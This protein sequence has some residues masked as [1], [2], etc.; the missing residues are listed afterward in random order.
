MMQKTIQ[1]WDL[2]FVVNLHQKHIKG[3]NSGQVE[4]PHS[5]SYKIFNRSKLKRDYLNKIGVDELNSDVT[6]TKKHPPPSGELEMNLHP[7]APGEKRDGY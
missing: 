5:K 6:F 3:S 1:D 4:R 2:N 7:Y